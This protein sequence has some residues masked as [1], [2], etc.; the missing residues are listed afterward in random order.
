MPHSSNIPNGLRVSVEWAMEQNKACLVV[1]TSTLAQGVNL[2]IRYLIVSST[3]QAGQEISTRDFHNLIGRAG[4]AGYHTEGSIIFADTDIYD[5]RR[6]RRKNWKW[7]RAIH[8]LDF[9]NAEDCLSSLKELIT[10][11]DFEILKVDVIHFIA[12]PRGYR[13]QHID[14]S[15]ELK[16][17]IA[18]LLEQM[19][20]KESLIQTIESYFLSHLK[21]NPG[22]DQAYF[23]DLARGTLAYFLADE[24]ERALFISAFELISRKVLS[25]DHQKFAYYGKTLLGVD[26]LV[27]IEDW[28][29]AN[30][31]DLEF[32][33]S[34]EDLLRICWSLIVQLNKNKIM[35]KIQPQNV[36][37][38]FAQ[39]WISGAS[40]SDLHRFLVENSAHY[41]ANT[42][43][44]NVKIDHVIDLADGALSFDS[45]LFIGAL[46]D[47]LEGHGFS[48]D[49]VN[50]LRVL[51]TRLKLGLATKLELWLYAKGFVDREVC[52]VLSS[53]LV[54]NGVPEENFD[55]KVLEQSN[56][57][58]EELLLM[59][60][61]YF[62]SVGSV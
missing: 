55:F 57:V 21:D 42:Q 31:L 38:D 25:L 36:L 24:E 14:L 56:Q 32:S 52:K 37:L 40:Y 50:N 2:P 8:L 60:P 39:K 27:S 19:N 28:I 29:S 59:L 48:E 16:I 58:V 4:R 43:Q 49:V 7:E 47:V 5:F 15:K 61:G 20:Y 54:A 6:D 45:M 1:C 3:F 11:F 18:S 33:D 41:Q 51:Q 10:P 46:A 12:D 17:D 22:I 44:R 35:S 34:P 13:Q 53:R 30:T 23:I 62:S 26:Q 9:T